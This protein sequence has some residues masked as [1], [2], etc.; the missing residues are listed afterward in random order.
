HF[1]FSYDYYPTAYY[2]PGGIVDIYRLHNCKQGT[3]RTAQH[4]YGLSGLQKGVGSSYSPTTGTGP[5][6]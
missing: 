1:D 6:P 2:R 4:P 5:A 3:G